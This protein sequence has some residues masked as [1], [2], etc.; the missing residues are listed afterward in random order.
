MSFKDFLPAAI[1]GG[2]GFII[3]ILGLLLKNAIFKRLDQSDAKLEAL[4]KAVQTSRE[5]MLK[6]YMT[7]ADCRFLTQ[8]NSDSHKELWQELRKA[9]KESKYEQ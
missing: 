1:S 4:G 8:Q 9:R 7:K 2:L 5:D 6:H 3:T